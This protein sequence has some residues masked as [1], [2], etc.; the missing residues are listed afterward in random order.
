MVLLESN[1]E[2]I[3]S[4]EEGGLSPIHIDP[5]ERGSES[6]FAVAHLTVQPVFAI[7]LHTDTARLVFPMPGRPSRRM[8]LPSREAS[9]IEEMS[10]SLPLILT[11]SG[12][13]PI[14][15][16]LSVEIR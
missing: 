4:M 10:S 14:N 15:A 2:E 5:I 6:A 1:L 8:L 11:K 3:D 13:G 16:P 12:I 9:V 7:S